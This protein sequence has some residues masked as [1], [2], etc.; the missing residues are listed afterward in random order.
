MTGLMG[1]APELAEVRVQQV[2]DAG[3]IRTRER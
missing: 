3:Q 2:V 1:L